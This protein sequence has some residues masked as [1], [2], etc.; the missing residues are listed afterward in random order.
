VIGVNPCSNHRLISLTSIISKIFDHTLSSHITK[1]L[2]IN[3]SLHQQQ[4]GFRCNCS[5]E[6]QLISLFQDLSLNYDNDTQ[7]DLIPLDFAKAFDTVPHNRL[8]YKL[9]WYGIQGSTHQWISQFLLNWSQQVVLNGTCSSSIPV[10][11]G[12]PPGTVLGPLLFLLYIN[13]LPNCTT[14]RFF[15][16]D[17]IVY[18]HIPNSDDADL[19]IKILIQL[20]NGLQYG[21]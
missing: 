19:C 18:R 16:D 9:Q 12:V 17:R 20:L 7:T 14:I 4:H 13:G 6:A 3:N 5:C 2:E 8:L 11:P 21:R 15:A 10:S 1:H